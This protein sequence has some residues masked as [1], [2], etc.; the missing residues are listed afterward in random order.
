MYATHT[1]K[2]KTLTW[3]G[4]ILNSNYVSSHNYTWSVDNHTYIH[5]LTYVHA[6]YINVSWCTTKYE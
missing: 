3:N 2:F 6:V 1:V 5:R 4:S